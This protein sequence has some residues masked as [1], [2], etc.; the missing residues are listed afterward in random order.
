MRPRNAVPKILGVV[1]LASVVALGG[2]NVTNP[3]PIQDAFLTDPISH[4]PLV[5]GAA[6]QLVGALNEVVL[7]VAYLGR[8]VLPGGTIGPGSPGGQIQ[9]AGGFNDLESNGPWSAVQQARFV[10]ELATQARVW[11]GFANR[12]L[13]EN[14]CEVVFD[15]GSIQPATAALQRAELHFTEVIN[16]ASGDQLTW[17]YAGRAQVRARLGQWATAE[18]DAMNVALDWEGELPLDGVENRNTMWTVVEATPYRGHSIRF[19]FQDTIWTNQG[20]PRAQWESVSGYPYAN[21]TLQGYGPVP[22]TRQVAKHHSRSDP[23]RLASG[24]EMYLIRAEAVLQQNGADWAEALGL[25]NQVRTRITSVTTST[26][27]APYTAANEDETW[28]ALMTEKGIETWL[29]GIRMADLGRW[30][31]ENRPG[32]DQQMPDFQALTSFFYDEPDRCF[33]ISENEQRTNPNIVEGECEACGGVGGPV[34]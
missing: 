30:E 19:T 13:G 27:L 20:D 16:S 14:F 17:G 11:A 21:S 5:N 33:P 12:I 7:S 34:G 3:G 32:V 29:E 31:E 15:G 9:Q 8:E 22:W 26:P 1:G 6:R 2:C 28:M 25:I 10:A 18:A 4:D 24:A 23:Y